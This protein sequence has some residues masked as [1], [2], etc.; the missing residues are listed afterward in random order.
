MIELRSSGSVR[1]WGASNH[2]VGTFRLLQSRLPFPLVT[3]KVEISC[4]NQVE[5]EVLDLAQE[6]RVRPMAWSPIESEP[7]LKTKGAEQTIK[8]QDTLHKL[9]GDFGKGVTTDQVMGGFMCLVI[10]LLS[11]ATLDSLRLYTTV[12]P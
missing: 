6:L 1:Y 9:A 5:N 2:S 7:I 4:F 11:V 10:L 3:N 12:K 8:L